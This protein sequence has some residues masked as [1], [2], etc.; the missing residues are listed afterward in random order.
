MKKK[1]IA[2][3][4]LSVGLICALLSGTALASSFP[5]VP[6]D[7]AYVEAVEYLNSA[8]IMVGD[9]NGNFNP[10][11]YV[12][13]AQMTAVICRMLGETENLGTNGDRFTDVPASYWANGYIIKAAEL[14]VV[15][16]YQD[17][18]FKPDNTVT[19]EQ[20]ITMVVRAMNMN[21]LAIAAGGYP[22]G[23]VS[24]ADEQGFLKGIQNLSGEPLKRATVAQILYNALHF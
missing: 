4:I 21:E 15:N 2:R 16:G 10:D 6:D 5:D 17:G 7:A 24:T 20:A 3:V 1:C 11:G 9:K 13:R 18:A 12:T 8:G 22:N 19:Y 14:E 23:Y